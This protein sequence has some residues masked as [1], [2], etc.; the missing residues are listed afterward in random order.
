MKIFNIEYDARW[1]CFLDKS[2]SKGIKQLPYQV[3][4]FCPKV[5]K[6]QKYAD[7]LPHYKV[8]VRKHVECFCLIDGRYSM[9]SYFV[10]NAFVTNGLLSLPFKLSERTLAS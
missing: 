9:S 4:L 2:C 10:Y 7:Y 3:S 8:L 6:S 5:P 1:G